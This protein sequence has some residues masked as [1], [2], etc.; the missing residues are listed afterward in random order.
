M[1]RRV[2]EIT[3]TVTV[4]PRPNGLP[5]AITQSP[6]R[7]FELSPNFT[8][9][10]G[11]FGSTR[12]SARSVLA[13]RPTTSATFS[14]VPSVRMAVISSAP[15]MTW[16]FVTIKPLGSMMKPDPSELA[17][18]PPPR[19][20]LSKKSWK[21]SSNGEPLGTSGM[22]TSLVSFIFCVVEMLTTAFCNPAAISATD[23]GPRLC[24]CAS[25]AGNVP[26]PRKTSATNAAARRKT[27]ATEPAA[28]PGRRLRNA[29][30]VAMCY[31]YLAA[32]HAEPA[33]FTS[34]HS[35]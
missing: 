35:S 5:I 1:S 31:S 4:P 8:E 19:S 23:A 34:A 33:T 16:L 28:C 30:P 18:C 24:A 26:R 6:T 11:S 15:S 29:K 13:S 21:N 2:A 7:I 12:S 25:M 14:L 22:G 17:R 9:V 20:S 27:D 3:P 32:L 10:S